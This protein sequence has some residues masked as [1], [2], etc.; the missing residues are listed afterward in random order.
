MINFFK[1]F[2]KPNFCPFLAHFHNF[3]GKKF[4]H[5]TELLPTTSEGF[6]ALCQNSEKSNDPI[7]RKQPA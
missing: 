5:K 7:P 4:F 2:K 6:L 1:K 3:W